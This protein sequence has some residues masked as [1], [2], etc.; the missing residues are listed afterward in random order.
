MTFFINK[1]CVLGVGLNVRCEYQ[2]ASIW[3]VT[4]KLEPEV[5]ECHRGAWGG[6]GRQQLSRPWKQYYNTRQYYN[7]MLGR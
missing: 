3:E 6:R 4:F 7:K 5:L 2:K 1:F